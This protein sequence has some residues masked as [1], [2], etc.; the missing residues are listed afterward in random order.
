MVGGLLIGGEFRLEYRHPTKPGWI[1][2][3]RNGVTTEGLNAILERMFR[4]QGG[5]HPWYIGLIDEAGFSAVAATDTHA[6]HPGWV[7]WASLV[8]PFRRAWDSMLANGGRMAS[9]SA[10]LFAI[11]GS[12]SIRGALLGSSPNI[13]PSPG[14][15]LYSTAVADEGLAVESPGALFVTYTLYAIPE[16]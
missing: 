10:T 2:V 15:T 11:T 16:N 1:R 14:H 5:T 13:G 8:G 9:G 3:L 7:E 4:G 12:G 6:S